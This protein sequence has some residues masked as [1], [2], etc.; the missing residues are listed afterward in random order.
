MTFQQLQKRSVYDYDIYIYFFCFEVKLLRMYLF[1]LAITA[2]TF[3][4]N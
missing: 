3:M 1:I 4:E 2:T